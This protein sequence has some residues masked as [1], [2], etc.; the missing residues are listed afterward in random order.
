[1]TQF[2][3][4][5]KLRGKYFSKNSQRTPA[6]PQTKE[7]RKNTTTQKYEWKE[8][9]VAKKSF[10]ARFT[11]TQSIVWRRHKKE[12]KTRSTI[13]TRRRRR[14]SLRG[15]S[16]FLCPDVRQH[17]GD[18]FEYLVVNGRVWGKRNVRFQNNESRSMSRLRTRNTVFL[19]A[20]AIFIGVE[21]LRSVMRCD[22][23]LYYIINHRFHICDRRRRYVVICDN[24]F[25]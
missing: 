2:S 19:N 8:L 4:T 12:D 9:F 18:L 15:G 11:K 10:R 20:D 22:F 23:F 17:N 1:M 21:W 6:H 7:R 16:S 25:S 14:G 24:C 3:F 5:S 13:S